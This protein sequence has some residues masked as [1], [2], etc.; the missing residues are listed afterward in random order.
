M[1]NSHLSRLQGS[2]DPMSLAHIVGENSRTQTKLAIVSFGD[3][4]S[5]GLEGSN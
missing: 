3:D 4:F 2:R 5:F 1:I